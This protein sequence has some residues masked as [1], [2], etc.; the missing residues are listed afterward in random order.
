M[1]PRF[2][3][4]PLRDFARFLIVK[5]DTFYCPSRVASDGGLKLHEEH[6][7]AWLDTWVFLSREYFAGAPVWELLMVRCYEGEGKLARMVCK[8]M[9]AEGIEGEVLVTVVEGTKVRVEIV[10]P[11]RKQSLDAGNVAEVE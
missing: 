5:K 1:H 7:Q 11:K 3:L 8:T 10:G 9:T 6:V 2:Y 4:G